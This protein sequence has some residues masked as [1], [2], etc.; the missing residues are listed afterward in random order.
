MTLLSNS[1]GAS[2][3]RADLGNDRV[4]IPLSSK[5][6]LGSPSRSN[7]ASPRRVLLES[8]VPVFQLRRK[9]LCDREA[10]LR[11][12]RARNERFS[13]YVRFTLT[14]SCAPHARTSTL[15]GLPN[16]LNSHVCGLA[17]RGGV[18]PPDEPPT[19]RSRRSDGRR[20]GA[21]S[22]A[23][24]AAPASLDSRRGE[25]FCPPLG[26]HFVFWSVAAE[27]D[28]VPGCNFLVGIVHPHPP[29]TCWKGPSTVAA[30]APHRGFFNQS[31]CRVRGP[32]PKAER[33]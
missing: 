12:P 31:T 11:A 23:A 22:A 5:R 15:P 10:V 4:R 33:G 17:T 24:C 29:F 30:P 16:P 14:R 20:A 28:H 8:P 6:G 7:H 32:G 1:P 19:H 3:R 13:P 2:T 18:G 25:G 26:G 9:S 27:A 21:A